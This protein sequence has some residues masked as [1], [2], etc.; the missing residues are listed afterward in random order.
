MFEADVL[1]RVVLCRDEHRRGVVDA[2]HVV[3]PE[4]FGRQ[5]SEFTRAA[6][7]IDSTPDRADIQLVQQVQQVMERLRPLAR[8][9]PVLLWVP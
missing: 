1:A 5:R 6:A 4:S 8:E 9:S 3:D 7:E 2:E